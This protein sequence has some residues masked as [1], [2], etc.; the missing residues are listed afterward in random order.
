MTLGSLAVKN[1][2][3]NPL[4]TMLTVLGVAIAILAF[5]FIRTI[6]DS[7]ATG[8]QHAAQ[9]R[10]STMH[11][12]SFVMPL[13]KKYVDEVRTVPGIEN[14]TFSNWFGGKHPTRETE[15]FQTLAV[16]TDTFLEVYSDMAVPPEQLE[17]W[18]ATTNGAIIGSS[19]AKQFGWKVGDEITLASAIFQG[20]WKL[21]R[22]S[23][24]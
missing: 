6:L 22:K 17:D 20:E 23:V 5:V 3:R 16:D 15:F 4:R 13:P 14:V 8:A 21:D 11:K 7:W 10:M 24:V 9:D 18:K 2:R 19:L 1:I 12:V